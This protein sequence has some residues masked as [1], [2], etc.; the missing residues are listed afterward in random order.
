M[1]SIYFVLLLGWLLSADVFASN[2]LAQPFVIPHTTTFDVIDPHKKRAYR[3]YVKLPVNYDPSISYPAIYM[4]DGDYLFPTLAGSLGI[5]M[6]ADK[7]INSFLVGIS[8]QRNI[9]ARKSR[10]RDYTHSVDESWK[11]ETG[12]A[13]QHLSF[14]RE[15]VIPTMESK[16]KT[17]PSSRTYIGNSLGGLFGGYILLNA[18]DTFKNYVLSS[19]SFWFN[20]ESLLKDVVK[21]KPANINA[22]V[23][24][25]VGALET[26]ATGETIHDMV[27]VAKRFHTALAS[28]ASPSLR[29]HFDQVES[30]NH[31]VAF[32]TSAIQGLYWLSKPDT[33]KHE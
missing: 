12:G 29:S 2:A 25:S 30:A 33:N 8:W 7:I 18:P 13:R 11:N 10:V 17:V 9:P 14:I 32:A 4:T 27:D 23:Y 26:P 6:S 15:V 19:P 21:F 3:V 1:K 31:E 5:P 16:Y 24:I 20:D 22:N 28:K